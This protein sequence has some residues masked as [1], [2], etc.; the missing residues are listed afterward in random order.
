VRVQPKPDQAKWRVEYFWDLRKIAV[1]VFALPIL[2]VMGILLLYLATYLFGISKSGPIFSLGWFGRLFVYSIG[3]LGLLLVMSALYVAVLTVRQLR[4]SKGPFFVVTD[5]HVIWR[6]PQRANPMMVHTASL[7]NAQYELDHFGDGPP[8]QYVVLYPKAEFKATNIPLSRDGKIKI[9]VSAGKGYWPGAVFLIQSAIVGSDVNL[10]PARH[11]P[12][13]FPAIERMWRK[14]LALFLLG[15]CAWGLWFDA[16]YIPIIQIH[17]H[18]RSATLI[19][20]AAMFWVLNLMATVMDHYDRRDNERVY[21][22]VSV[23]AAAAS[24]I[25]LIAAFVV[26]FSPK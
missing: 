24:A 11:I 14:L 9:H 2:L 26:N 18:G 5:K 8:N 22:I 20:L 16:M 3:A 13:E 1:A 15:Y 17:F 23:A 7:R 25:A 19:A 12:N 21:G 6:D 4:F 10:E